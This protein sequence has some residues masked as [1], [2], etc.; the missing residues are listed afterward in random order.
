MRS[1]KF[2]VLAHDRTMPVDEWTD[3]T[4]GKTHIRHFPTRDHLEAFIKEILA[5][6][7]LLVNNSPVSE[8]ALLTNDSSLEFW[9]FRRPARPESPPTP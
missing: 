3:S 8:T 4:G 1:E 7:W 2:R 6:G 5:E 9:L